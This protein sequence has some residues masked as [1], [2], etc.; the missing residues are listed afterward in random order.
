MQQSR[1]IVPFEENLIRARNTY[2][3]E[4]AQDLDRVLDAVASRTF[5]RFFDELLEW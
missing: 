3:E 2:F 4:L 1:R 5:Y